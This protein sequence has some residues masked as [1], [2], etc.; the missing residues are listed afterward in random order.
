MPF[1][2]NILSV[3]LIHTVTEP[4]AFSFMVQSTGR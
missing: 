1:W 2:W 3:S 4:S